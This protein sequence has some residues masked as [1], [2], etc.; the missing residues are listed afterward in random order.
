MNSLWKRA[1]IRVLGMKFIR[2]TIFL[3]A[4]LLLSSCQ[5]NSVQPPSGKPR[6]LAIESYLTDMTRSVAGDRLEVDTLIPLGVDPH[7]F[8]ATPKDIAR[9]SES[10]VLIINGAGFEPWMDK[11]LENAGGQRQLIEATQGLTSRTAREGEAAMHVEE[12]ND[13]ETGDPHFWLD[14]LN[15]VHYVE[16]IRDGLILADPDGRELYTQ[17]AAAYIDDLKRLDTWIQEQVQTIPPE[18][19]QIVTNHESLGY[20]ADRYG[21]TVIGTIVPSVSTESSPSAQQLAL[22]VDTIRQSGARV[23]F[24]ETGANPQLAE[25]IAQETGV[26]VVADL[27]THSLSGPDGPAPSY[28]EMMRYNT[29]TIVDALK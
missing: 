15:A 11:T 16:N 29:R 4:T 7:A 27:Y 13:Q 6:V 1:E 24:L 12:G 3:L 26:K 20:Y 21:F 5:A 23:I 10:S 8:E 22:L 25:Q 2:L 14:P 19:R 18:Q 9:I 28:M 17:N